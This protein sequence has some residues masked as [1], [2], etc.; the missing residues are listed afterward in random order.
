MKT[1]IT[2]RLEDDGTLSARATI[3]DQYDSPLHDNAAHVTESMPVEVPEAVK[4]A[5]A[6]V[7]ED[8]KKALARKLNIAKAA[9]ITSEASRTGKHFSGGLAINKE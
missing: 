1:W 4:T 5:L 6:A 9:V 2:L 3:Q 8:T 7:L